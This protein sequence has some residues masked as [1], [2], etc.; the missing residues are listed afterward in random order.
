MSKYIYLLMLLTLGYTSLSAQQKM[1]YYQMPKIINDAVGAHTTLILPIGPIT[2]STLTSLSMI[3][4]EAILYQ[5]V[6]YF[7]PTCTIFCTNVY[8]L[9]YTLVQVN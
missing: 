4:L 9:L 8:N 7:V 2:H 3:E 5:R 1:P 6:Q